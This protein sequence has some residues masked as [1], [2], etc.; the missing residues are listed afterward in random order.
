MQMDSRIILAGQT[1]D[2]IGQMQRG[3]QMAQFENDARHQNAFRAMLQQ[4]GAGIMGGDANALAQLAQFDP[5]AALGV[6]ETRQSMAAREEQLQMARAQAARAAQAWAQDQNAATI[7]R[8]R[9]MLSTGLRGAAF[10]YGQG[11]R[12]GYERFLT[13]QGLD[14]AQY[15][16]DQFPAHAAMVEG[17]LG[18]LNQ[19]TPAQA[20]PTDRYRVMGGQLVDL[21][22]EGGPRVVLEA[23]GQSETIFGPDGNPILQRGPSRAFTEGQSRDVVYSTRARGALEAFEPVANALTSRGELLAETVPLGL[24]RGMQSPEFQQAMTA[25]T[26]FLQAILRK[27]TGA[28]ITTQEREEYG[29][30]YLPQ[31]GDTPEQL[32]IRADARRRAL[33]AIE[34]GMSVDQIAVQTRALGEQIR[35]AGAASGQQAAPRVDMAPSIAPQA[36]RAAGGAQVPPEAAQMLM[37]DPSPEAQQEFDA[38]FGPG[39]ARRI[40]E[41]TQ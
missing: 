11:D 36:P 17:V 1:P 39:A 10:F 28:A 35:Q 29:R 14:P 25:G 16:F 22:A 41:G 34:A 23:P 15:S 37:A 6:Q 19:F 5:Q 32:Q 20:D 13:Q 40:L 8:E 12:A 38:V 7:A 2:I 26:E 21:T 24:A 9:E 33:A 31:P 4:N 30:V 27:D 3:A 18:V